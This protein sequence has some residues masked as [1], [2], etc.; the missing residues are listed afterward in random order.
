MVAISALAGL[1]VKLG[2]QLER[3][4]S[5]RNHLRTWYYFNVVSRSISVLASSL[6]KKIFS[7]S[8]KKRTVSESLRMRQAAKIRLDDSLG[9]KSDCFTC[10]PLDNKRFNFFVYNGTKGR[11]CAENVQKPK[12]CASNAKIGDT[13]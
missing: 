13:L 4:P 3:G 6:A 2:T 10:Y 12:T 8:C 5:R 11:K 1:A 7:A 9:L